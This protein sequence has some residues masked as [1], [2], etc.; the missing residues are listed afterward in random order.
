LRRGWG[1]ES[2]GNKVP[3]NQMIMKMF[4]K[5]ETKITFAEYTR[6]RSEKNRVKKRGEEGG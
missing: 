4:H 1:G 3:V 2:P 5:E 6:D